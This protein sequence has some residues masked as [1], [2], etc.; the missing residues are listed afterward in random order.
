MLVENSAP[1]LLKQPLSGTNFQNSASNLLKLPLSGTDIKKVL[2][3]RKNLLIRA[4]YLK[5]FPY[6]CNASVKY[7]LDFS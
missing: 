1:N 2:Y 3:T 6:T 5:C 7:S 4:L